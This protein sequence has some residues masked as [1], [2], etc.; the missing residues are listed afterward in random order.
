MHDYAVQRGAVAVVRPHLHDVADVHHQRIAARLDQMPVVVVEHLEARL[1]V[2][3]QQ[4][5][6]AG[7]GVRS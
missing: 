3:Q 6:R 4:R 1:L 7:V 5:D 2:L